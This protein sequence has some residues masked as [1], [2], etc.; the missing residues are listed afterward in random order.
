LPIHV[1]TIAGCWLLAV[2]VAAVGAHAAQPPA[3]QTAPAGYV[4]P[5]HPDIRGHEG[6]TCGKCGMRLVPAAAD[7]TPYLL[8]VE[9]SPRTIRAG[10]KGRVRF[11]VRQPATG[12]TVRR[13]ETVH[14]RVFHLFVV[15]RDLEYFAHVHPV[16]HANGAL[17]VDITVPRP[18]A[19]QLI[20]DFLPSGGAPQLL[21]RSFVTAGYR[22]VLGAAP[23]LSPD[24]SDKIAGGVRV[25]LV[26][27]AAR[28]RREQ[29]L[30][31]EMT[32]AAS[33]ATI[34]D[35]EP[36]L[37]A[38]GHLLVASAD[39]AVAF[40]SHPVD[41]VSSR[42]GPRIVFQVL[43]PREGVYRMWMQF[44]RGGRVA[45]VSFTIP[46]AGDP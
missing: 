35:L 19:Y 14:E 15:S 39:L 5:M 2:A 29:L 10:E 43:W 21:Q 3:S 46:V 11:F 31:F 6:D 37:G 45:T 7:Y 8:D 42:S 44:Q 36:Y 23:A 32:D 25:T 27:P 12:A 16:L 26:P 9:W 30:T 18:G 24:L 4:C 22:G 41:G 20:A 38:T 1:R 13:F 33:G 17:D 28:A 40:H 34:T